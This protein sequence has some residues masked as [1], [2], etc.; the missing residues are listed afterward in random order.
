MHEKVIIENAGGGGEQEILLV[1]FVAP[2]FAESLDKKRVAGGDCSLSLFRT[3]FLPLVAAQLDRRRQLKVRRLFG[4][5]FA[6][7]RLEFG[8]DDTT[9][10]A[11]PDGKNFGGHAVAGVENA[12]GAGIHVFS[13]R[14]L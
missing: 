10:A 6:L 2:A 11:L 5:L 1:F 12:E 14:R 8:S 9:L 3:D 4:F 7:F 13:R